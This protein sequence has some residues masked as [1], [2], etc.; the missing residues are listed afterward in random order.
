LAPRFCSYPYNGGGSYYGQSTYPY[1]AGTAYR[2]SG[3]VSGQGYAS[4]PYAMGSYGPGWP[5]STP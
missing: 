4:A 2:V 5:Y 1:S 3:T